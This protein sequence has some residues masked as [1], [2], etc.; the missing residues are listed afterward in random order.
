MQRHRRPTRQFFSTDFIGPPLP[1]VETN[2][3]AE[4]QTLIHWVRL[5]FIVTCVSSVVCLVF[6]MVIAILIVPEVQQGIETTVHVEERLLRLTNDHET[7]LLELI[8]NLDNVTSMV[9]AL[10]PEMGSEIMR[11]LHDFNNGTVA[12]IKELSAVLTND[13]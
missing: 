13:D 11:A 7:L 5:I 6:A 3:A 10:V 9:S 2:I 12:A 4:I 8:E 1:S